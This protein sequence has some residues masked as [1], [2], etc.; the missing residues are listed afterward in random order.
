MVE[1]CPHTLHTLEH[2]FSRTEM[3]IG[4]EALEKLVKSKVAVFGVG[5]VGS[6]V[7]EGLARAGI[8]KLIL[9]DFD[10]VSITNIN[11]QLPALTS[12]I[13]R[14][15]VEVVKERVLDI[16]PDA[17]VEIYKEFYSPDNSDFFIR[18]E[19]DY[20]VDA[21]DSVKSKIDLIIKAQEKNI[22]VISSMGAGNKLDPAKL[23]V[24]DIY[25]TSVCP[26]AKVVRKEL[27][28]KGV[29]SHK[30]VFSTEQP[31]KINCGVQNGEKHTPGSVSFVPSVAGLIIAGEVVRSL[32]NWDTP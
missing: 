31:I 25:D 11:R 18:K 4:A 17:E 7:V 14:P 15:K 12:T 22:P 21:I 20:I 23:R 16:N 10:T 2:R 19:Y 8:G 28:K 26:L 32:I 27:R 5:G 9:I 29:L 3:L 1:E 6:Y 30:V 13:G 24:A